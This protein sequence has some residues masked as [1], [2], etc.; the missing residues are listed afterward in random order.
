MSSVTREEYEALLDIVHKQGLLIEKLYYQN[1]RFL[2]VEDEHLDQQLSELRE[3]ESR[4][5]VTSA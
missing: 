3:Q 5:K 1:Q 4:V 2:G